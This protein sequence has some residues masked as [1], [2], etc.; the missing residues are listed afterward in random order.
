LLAILIFG[1]AWQVLG[2]PE[3][4]LIISITE[5]LKP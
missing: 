4:S 2:H 3:S 5:V 1:I